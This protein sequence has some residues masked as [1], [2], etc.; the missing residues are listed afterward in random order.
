MTLFDTHCHLDSDEFGPDR[1]AVMERMYTCGVRG[2]A[3]IAYDHA[4]CSRVIRF[5]EEHPGF[6]A[7]VGI[8]PEHASEMKDDM[9]DV[10]RAYCGHPCVHAIG[11]IGLDTHDALNPPME[12]QM[13]ALLCQLELA[14]QTSLPVAFHVR[15]AH[16]LLLQTLKARR[17]RLTGGVIH[18]YSGS[19]EMAKEYLDLGYYLAFGGAS[20]YPNAHK[21]QKVLREMP[22]DRLLLETDSPYMPPEG[23]RGERNE[24]GWIQDVCIRVAEIRG[25]DPE[26]LAWETWNNALRM[27]RIEQKTLQ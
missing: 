3:L 15:N 26:T 1:D 7:A 8:H 12:V 17:G 2:A 5:C 9:L 20:T 14:E 22:A 4:S 23:H 6:V 27:Y 13:H 25:T 21:A 11:E 18:C 10:L 16:P 19:W 24:P